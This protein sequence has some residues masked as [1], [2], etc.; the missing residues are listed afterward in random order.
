[1]EETAY[2]FARFNRVDEKW[3]CYQKLNSDKELAKE[4]IDKTK[5]K[6][7]CI[8]HADDSKFGT[9]DFAIKKLIAAGCPG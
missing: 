2:D 4:C 7:D 8:R 1:M 6:T 9:W 5:N 3:K